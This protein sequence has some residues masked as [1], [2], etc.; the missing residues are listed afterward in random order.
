MKFAN[1]PR[2]TVETNQKIRE[3]MAKARQQMQ[4]LTAGI[5]PESTKKPEPVN[6]QAMPTK[7]SHDD[8]GAND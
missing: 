4:T 8:P 1:N 5:Y 6:P 2:F 3:T 7:P